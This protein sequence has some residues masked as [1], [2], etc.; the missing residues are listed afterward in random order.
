MSTHVKHNLLWMGV[1]SLF[2]ATVSRASAPEW[3]QWRGPNRDGISEETGL[4]K[5][6][7]E[8]GPKL[9]WKI[10]G[11]GQGF[12]GVSLWGDKIFSMG[13]KEDGSYLVCLNKADGKLLWSTRVGKSGGNDERRPGP[14]CTPAVDG[15]RVIAV[16][17]FGEIL[18]A[19]LTTGKEIW[20]KSYQDDFGG[21]SVPRWNFSD[22]PLLDG[23]QVIFLPGGSKGTMVA[24]NKETGALL[25][26]SSEITDNASYSSVI[27]SEIEGVRQYIA[28]TDVRLFGVNPKDGRVLWQAP[29]EVRN[30]IPTPI[31]RDGLLFIS[32]GYNAGCHCFKITQ[33]DG[34]FKAERIYENR[35]IANQHG[36]AILVGDHVYVSIDQGGKLTCLDFNTGKIAWQDNSVGKASLGYADGHLIV[37]SENGPVALVEATPEGYKEKGRFNQPDRSEYN[38]WPHPVIADGQLYLRDNDVLLCYDLIA[39]DSKQ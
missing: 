33:V 24:L 18:C 29:R 13:D 28:A 26:Q 8:G 9:A 11:M 15:K 23:E 25:W 7:P 31:Y 37:R 12:S 2:A 27:A 21:T 14:R 38:S 20:R 1:I 16:G 3:N 19:D 35:D 4:L 5:S 30:V 36:G 32:S 22:S 39:S 6:W 17:Q 34:T 10:T